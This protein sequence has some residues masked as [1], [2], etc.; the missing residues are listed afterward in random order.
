MAHEGRRAQNLPA[1]AISPPLPALPGRP[2]VARWLAA[3]RLQNSS[4][5]E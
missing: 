1:R 2:A 4:P 3:R 5:P